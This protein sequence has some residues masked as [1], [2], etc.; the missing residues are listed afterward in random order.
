[1]FLF[2]FTTSM[3]A[4][5]N[6]FVNTNGQSSRLQKMVNNV[7]FSAQSGSMC[8]QRTTSIVL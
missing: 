8:W 6:S 3:A 1:M 2:K 7:N 5:R 4:K